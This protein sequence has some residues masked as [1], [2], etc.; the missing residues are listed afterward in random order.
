VKVVV[1]VVVVVAVLLLLLRLSSRRPTSADVRQLAM[2]L[3]VDLLFPVVD[4]NQVRKALDMQRCVGLADGG[5]AVEGRPPGGRGGATLRRR[6]TTGDG[7]G[8]TELVVRVD[9]V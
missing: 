4:G 9:E 7:G 2:G 8:A 6:P 5:Q 3:Y 1:V